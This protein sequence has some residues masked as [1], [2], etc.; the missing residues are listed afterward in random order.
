M[1]SFRIY[2]ED[3]PAPAS[4]EKS[5]TKFDEGRYKLYGAVWAFEDEG[6]DIEVHIAQKRRYGTVDASERVT[7]FNG[8]GVYA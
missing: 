2:S 7:G 1:D 4:A 6:S 8:L 3:N 5:Y